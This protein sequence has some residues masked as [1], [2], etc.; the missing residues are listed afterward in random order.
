LLV[1]QGFLGSER[2]SIGRLVFRGAQV[3][4]NTVKLIAMNGKTPRRKRM[5]SD[6]ISSRRWAAYA[7]AGVAST[8][9]LAPTTEAEVHYS[10]IVNYE[11]GQHHGHGTFPLDPGI[12]LAMTIGIPGSSDAFGHAS[13]KGADGAFVG[14]L[15]IYTSPFASSLRAG[16]KLSHQ[17]FPVSCRWSSSRSMQVCY[18]S[19][20]NIGD[21]SFETRGTTFLGFKFTNE[22]GTHYGWARVRLSGAPKFRFELVDYAWADAG[23]GLQTGQKKSLTQS[24]VTKSGSLGFLATGAAGL[25]A[26]RSEK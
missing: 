14:R 5:V 21:G 3:Y 20:D 22:S 15:G 10:G 8:V 26:W 18:Y 25:K 12:D 9:A 19:G 17:Q 16:V 7:A 4:S 2:F 1:G 11:F 23:E 13:V 6:S 24:A